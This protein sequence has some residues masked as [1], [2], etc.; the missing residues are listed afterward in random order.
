MNTQRNLTFTLTLLAAVAAGDAALAQR[1]T[2]VSPGSPVGT[3]LG[4][5]NRFDSTFNPAVSL[6]VDAWGNWGDYGE[7]GG[8]GFDAGLRRVDFLVA[9]WID[10]NALAWIT[11]AYE[12][13]EFGLEEGAIEYVGLPGNW[14]LR[15]GRFFVDFGKQMQAHIE[16]LRTFDRP[17][18]LREYLGEELPGD[19]LQLDNWVGLGEKTLVRYSIGVFGDLAGEAH[20]HGEEEGEAEPEVHLPERADAGDLGYTAR[21]TALTEVGATGTLQFGGSMRL[22]SGF[23]LEVD[24]TDLEL[25]DLSNAVYGLDL[26]YGWVAEDGMRN[27][28]VGGEYL[29]MD[30]DLG[31]EIDE[32]ADAND[33]LDDTLNLFSGSVSG[34][35]GFVDYGFTQVDS[36]GVQ[37]SFAQEPEEGKADHTELDLYYTKRLSDF[38]RIRF[39]ATFGDV[40][41]GEDYTRFGV[42]L[43]GFIGPHGHGLNW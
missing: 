38:L 43:T 11:V 3:T 15:A 37:Y 6:A 5:T 29:F 20:G 2:I 39:G 7:E 36:V 28:T 26:T 8:K 33:P 14:S 17:L 12:E 19:G 40:E 9:D 34:A 30:G 16:Q 35:Y 24:G 23:G 32:G 31:A 13:E 18:V 41:G 27:F 4:Q 1:A 22:L 21:V 25:E 10:P 42:Q